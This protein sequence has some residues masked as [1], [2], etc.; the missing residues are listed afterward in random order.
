M[1]VQDKTY[2]WHTHRMQSQQFACFENSMP[3][4]A[5]N[6][7]RWRHAEAGDKSKRKLSFCPF[8]QYSGSNDQSYLNH[9]LWAHYNASYRCGKCINKVFPSGQWLKVHMKCCKGL[10]A[11]AVREKP[12]TSHTKGA[13][14]SSS[15]SK[16]KKHQTTSHSRT[17][18]HFHQL[19]PK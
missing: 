9:I 1:S 19:A 13:S 16:E 8:C 5:F 2:W 14:S 10:K 4:P 15:S 3:M 17:P 6:A 11:E 12:A 7:L 18:R